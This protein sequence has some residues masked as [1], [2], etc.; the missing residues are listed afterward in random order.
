MRFRFRPALTA[1]TLSALAILCALGAWQ[2]KRLHWKNELIAKTQSRLSAAPIAFGEALRRAGAGEDMEYQPVIAE[3]AW[4]DAR[5]AKVFSTYQGEPGVL[6][7]TP[8]LTDAA[9][10]YVNRGFVPQ[11]LAGDIAEGENAPVRIQ[12]LFRH[13]EQKKGLERIFAAPDQPSDNLFFVRDPRVLAAPYGF[14]APPFYIDSF[15]REGVEWPKGGLTRVA[16]PN[17]HLEYALTW[18]GLAAALAGVYLAFSF[19]R[20]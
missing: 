11:D 19:R 12:G 15:A 10:V 16:F 3:G 4:D 9:T 20:D 1:A 8:L 18:F 6:I 14:D 2:L 5:T 13:A 17:R 7:F